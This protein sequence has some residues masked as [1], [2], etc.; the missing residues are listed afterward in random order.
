MTARRSH[1]RGFTL[2]EVVVALLVV[3]LGIGTLLTTL[4]S[5]ARTLS[6]LRDRTFAEWIALN[7][8][9]E[10][11]LATA[12]PGVATTRG[13]IEY[14]GQRWAWQQVVT[15]PG[16]AGILRIDV[17]VALLPEGQDAPPTPQDASADSFPA[18]ATAY[19]FLGTAI[20]QP[21]GIDPDWSLEAAA[22][23]GGAPGQ[24][25]AAPEPTP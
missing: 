3:A 22:P 4:T 8:L 10:L 12:R 19:G 21:S 5:S 18:L 13:T 6:Q 20:G 9:S 2:I 15:D 25:G 16:M 17:S 11:R 1:A 14:A 23:P 24:G 7:R